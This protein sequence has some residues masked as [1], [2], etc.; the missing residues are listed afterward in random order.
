MRMRMRMK[1][2]RRIRIDI[3]HNLTEMMQQRSHSRSRGVGILVVGGGQAKA[4][5]QDGK[6]G[7][8]LVPAILITGTEVRGSLH[9]G[10]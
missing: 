8:G 10:R 4:N 5:F 6:W 9:V 7:R 3:L 1:T 2:R